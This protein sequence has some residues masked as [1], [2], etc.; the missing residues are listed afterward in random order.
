MNLQNHPM[1][2][3]WDWYKSVHRQGP[4]ARWCLLS[5]LLFYV[6]EVEAGVEGGTEN[7]TL[8]NFKDVLITQIV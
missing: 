3:C 7:I 5:A 8:A 1:S 2:L 6:A 4:Y